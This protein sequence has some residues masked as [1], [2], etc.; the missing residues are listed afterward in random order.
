[1]LKRLLGYLTGTCEVKD[2]APSASESS[3]SNVPKPEE[4]PYRKTRDRQR[5][6]LLINALTA[7]SRNGMVVI[8]KDRLY[9]AQDVKCSFEIY[10]Y[11]IVDGYYI[12]PHISF[13]MLSEEDL[14]NYLDDIE[15][16]GEWVFQIPVLEQWVRD[17]QYLTDSLKMLSKIHDGP[18][19]PTVFR[20]KGEY[21]LC[22]KVFHDMSWIDAGWKGPA[23]IIEPNPSIHV[24]HTEGVIP[25]SSEP[26]PFHRILTELN[27]FNRTYMKDFIATYPAVVK[28]KSS[29]IDFIKIA[30]DMGIIDKNAT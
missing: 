4:K 3:E 21:R 28:F 17:L 22:I 8:N 11:K 1:M 6:Q 16:P 18:Y 20:L 13:K 23:I 29:Y 19:D 15:T 14:P 7:R 10:G 25:D 24:N 26:V 27:R 5:N 12:N 9:S 2:T 30:R